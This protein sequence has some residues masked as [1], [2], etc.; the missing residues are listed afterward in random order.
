VLKFLPAS[1][2]TAVTLVEPIG[3]AVLAFVFLMQV[4]SA[5]ELTGGLLVIAGL[6]V[7]LRPR[8]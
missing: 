3:A 5:L 1:T 4:P 8:S 2:V 7:A 6:F